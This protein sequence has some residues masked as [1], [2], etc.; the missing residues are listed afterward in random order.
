MKD[1]WLTTLLPRD[2][3]LREFA[4]RPFHL[5]TDTSSS[6]LKKDR[7]L[8]LW[9]VEGR[10]KLCYQ[11]YVSTLQSLLR[12]PVAD[13]RSKLLGMFTGLV[14]HRW[15]VPALGLAAVQH[16]AA[17]SHMSVPC[18][19]FLLSV[20]PH[21]LGLLSRPLLPRVPCSRACVRPPCTVSRAGAVS[22]VHVGQQAW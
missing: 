12:D 2:R 21:Y 15:P 22:L 1:L 4:S 17:A 8:L 13:V 5:L 7:E 19:F 11:S 3:K 14:H 20:G 18:T 10:V 16:E 6:Q 9:H